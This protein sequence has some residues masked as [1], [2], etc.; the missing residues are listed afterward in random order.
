MRKPAAP[1][2][3]SK[4]KAKKKAA[5]E[6]AEIRVKT[7]LSVPEE[8]SQESVTDCAQAYGNV[9]MDGSRFVV[10]TQVENEEESSLG[11]TVHHQQMLAV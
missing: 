11:S 2:A 6:K 5:Q 7:P 3:P 8:Q 9:G 10:S 4:K 1:K